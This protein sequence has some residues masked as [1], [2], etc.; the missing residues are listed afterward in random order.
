MEMLDGLLNVKMAE[1]EEGV[2]CRTDYVP[3]AGMAGGEVIGDVKTGWCAEKAGGE[4][5]RD[6]GLV[7]I[8]RDD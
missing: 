5:T 6:V 2:L 4:V 7:A 8:R 1:E 3:Y